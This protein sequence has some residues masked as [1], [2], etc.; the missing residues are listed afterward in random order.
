MRQK[1]ADLWNLIYNFRNVII[2]LLLFIAGTIFRLKNYVDGEGWVTLMKT[3]FVA[4]AAA[5]TSEHIVSVVKE[6]VNVA[7]GPSKGNTAP[8]P[9]SGN[10]VEGDGK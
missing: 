2:W 9:Q 10:L 5:H 3:T 6:Y 1:M 7:N 4:L 8:D